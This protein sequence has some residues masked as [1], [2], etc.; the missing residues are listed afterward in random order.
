MTTAIVPFTAA[1]LPAVVRFAERTWQWRYDAD[2]YRWR[3]LQCPASMLVAMRGNECLAM[4]SAFSRSYLVGGRTATYAETFDW[5]TVPEYRSSGLGVLLLKEMMDRPDPILVV[6]G[7][8]DTTTI[9]P[10]MGWR[11]LDAA[12]LYTLP[13]SG[14]SMS[15]RVRW[16]TLR[17]VVNAVFD[18]SARLWFRPRQHGPPPGT[19]TESADGVDER[20]LSLYRRDSQYGL[21]P[22]PDLARLQ[23][24]TTGQRGTTRF[25]V[26]YFITDGVLSG[27]SL[28]KTSKTRS[29]CEASLLECYAPHP[30]VETY[31]SMVAETVLRVM[32]FQPQ[33]VQARATCAMLQAALRRNRFLRRG[34]VPVRFWSREQTSPPPPSHLAYNVGDADM[35][36]YPEA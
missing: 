25:L 11:D 10:R 17:P 23:W 4:L 28:A 19:E 9:L 20:V 31:V 8:A 30:T 36:P 34:S 1:L 29:G 14:A 2:M 5:Y 15:D 6:G 3:F 7:S 27:W 21:V 26:S 33:R 13:L 22:I 16:R 12:V 24:L 18:L 35:L 32:A